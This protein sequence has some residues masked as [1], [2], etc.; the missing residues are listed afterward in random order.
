MHRSSKSIGAIAAT[1]AKPQ[2]ELSNPEKSLIGIIGPWTPREPGR[3]FRYAPLSSGVEIVRKEP[4]SPWSPCHRDRADHRDRQRV[5]PRPLR[6]GA[7]SCRRGNGWPRNRTVESVCAANRRHP[8]GIHAR[9]RCQ[10]LQGVCPNLNSSCFREVG[11]A[12]LPI[13]IGFTDLA[14]L[15]HD[16]LPIDDLTVH[17][18]PAVMTSAILRLRAGHPLKRTVRWRIVA[19]ELLVPRYFQCSAGKS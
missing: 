18:A 11:G 1:L 12:E 17:E 19:N 3:A 9:R 13:R 15:N 10:L 14:R 6:Y 4:W 8:P 5:R 16:Q 7:G 2:A